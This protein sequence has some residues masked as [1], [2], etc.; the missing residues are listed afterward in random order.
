MGL[1]RRNPARTRLFTAT[2]TLAVFAVPEPG[3][4]EAAAP[5]AARPPEAKRAP[6]ITREQRHRMIS[7]A[8]Y[9]L[10]ERAGFAVD[11]LQSW[12]TAERAVDAELERLA[13]AAA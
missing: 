5:Q 7:R 13:R 10:A 9:G 12:L 1:K 6:L 11:P 2:P 3:A 4:P 8:A